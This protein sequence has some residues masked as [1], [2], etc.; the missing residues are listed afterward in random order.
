MSKFKIVLVAPEIPGNTGSIGR[1]CVA[2]DLE[3]IL[4][5]PLAFDI[6]EKAVRRAGL[7]YWKHVKLKI[8]DS[9]EDFIQN[10]NPSKDKLFYFSRFATKTIFEQKLTRDSY[11]IFGSETKGLPKKVMEENAE[12]L[13]KFPMYSEHIR[14]LNL[15][16]VATAAAYEAIR[17]IEFNI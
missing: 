3:L 6:D 4:I 2:L 14:S 11:L 17:Q 7:D 15:S 16:N 13:I 9:Y 1:T 5:K 8:Y 10:E 12:Q